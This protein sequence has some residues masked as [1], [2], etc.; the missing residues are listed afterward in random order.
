MRTHSYDQAIQKFESALKLDKSNEYI[1]QLIKEA[2]DAWERRQQADRH[3]KE[4]Q[5]AM[6][7]GDLT[8]AKKSVEEAISASPEHESA[9][10]LLENLRRKVEAR[11]RENQLREGLSRAK[12]LMLLES[13]D[14]AIELLV[15]LQKSFPGSAEVQRILRD[16]RADQENRIRARELQSGTDEVKAFLKDQRFGEA[17]ALLSKLLVKFPESKELSTLFNYAAEEQ[18]VRLEARAVEFYIGFSNQDFHFT[19][20]NGTSLNGLSIL[21]RGGDSSNVFFSGAQLSTVPATFAI[22]MD[23]RLSQDIALI[24]YGVTDRLDVSLGLPTIH[25]AVSARTYAGTI[26]AGNGQGTNGSTCWCVDTFTPGY[27]TLLEP[28][29]GQ[30]AMAKMGFGDL[31]LRVKGTVVRRPNLVMAVGGDIRFPTGDAQNYPRRRD[32]HI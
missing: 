1:R 25:S 5:N 28:Q 17:E 20:F 32:N 13:I 2:Q 10:E 26:Y 7:A 12:R 18:R 11:E 15:D 6:A 27:Y 30:S 9:K 16:A 8:A 21:Y 24:T 31:L 29:I 4:A 19:K 22:G 3:V 23:V 14:T